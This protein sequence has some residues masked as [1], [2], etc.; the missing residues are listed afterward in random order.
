MKRY[1][2][3]CLA[4][5]A[6]ILLISTTALP[7]A[8]AAEPIRIGVLATL[9][10]PFAALG[11]EGVDGVKMAF[12]EFNNELGGRPVKLFIED[13]SA[14]PDTAVTKTRALIS[15]DKCQLVLGP[16]SGAEGLA[17]KKSAD[18]WPNATIVVTASAAEDITMRGVKPNI[19]RCSFSGAQPMF[20]L[21]EYVY[22]HGYR[23]V[24]TLG[25]DYAYPYAHVGGFLKA[26][27]DS[28]GCVAKKFWVPIGTSDYSAL[29]SQ[30]PKDIDAFYF[31]LGGTDAVNFMRSLDEFGMIGK[32][33]IFAGATSIDVSVLQAVG[34]Q[35]DG[36]VSGSI[37][38]ADVD[39][40]IYR[41]FDARY[42]KLRGRTPSL[43]VDCYYTATKWAALAL[44][45]VNG[46]IEDQAAYR[47]A[48]Q[49]TAFDAPRGHVSFDKFHNVVEDVYINQVKLVEGE[50]RNIN[51]E[52]IPKVSQ[53]W[54]YDPEEYQKQPPYDRKFPDK[55]CK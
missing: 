46:N 11:E 37:V 36:I 31:C 53:F 19:W 1:L 27:I 43:F 49:N 55:P 12:E 23:K 51:I 20:P 54:H 5:F 7:P 24:A 34:K 42:R 25:E 22:N 6:A 2:R 38:A 52:V 41:E 50:Y 45:E 28:G 40:P 3:I 16:L 48:L 26:F 44:K 33:P 47:E 4:A 15:R 35:C 8:Q 9:T 29:V 32:F 21:G 13:T 30:I 10:G 18:E 39:T 17:I 14:D